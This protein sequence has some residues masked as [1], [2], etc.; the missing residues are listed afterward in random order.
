MIIAYRNRV[1]ALESKTTRNEVFL[2][3]ALMKYI[4]NCSVHRTNY[5]YPNVIYCNNSGF[6]LSSVLTHLCSNTK[7]MSFAGKNHA[8]NS[9]IKVHGLVRSAQIQAKLI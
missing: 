8:R 9:F 1:R 4:N 6:Q 5:S 7:V 2:L 3:L